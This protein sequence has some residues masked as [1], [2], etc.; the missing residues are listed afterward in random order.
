L[1]GLKEEYLVRKKDM[2]P[3]ELFALENIENTDRIVCEN[4]QE[5]NEARMKFLKTMEYLGHLPEDIAKNIETSKDT[6]KMKVN[7]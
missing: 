3:L 2:G 1:G 4:P 7:C 5:T 6:D